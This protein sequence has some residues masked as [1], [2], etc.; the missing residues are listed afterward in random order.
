MRRHRARRGRLEGHRCVGCS[1]RLS[2]MQQ[3]AASIMMETVLGRSHSLCIWP[4]LPRFVLRS[5]PAA[6][7]FKGKS[8]A[9]GA[10]RLAMGRPRP[11]QAR[12]ACWSATRPCSPWQA[13]PPEAA[14]SSRF[15]STAPEGATAKGRIDPEGEIE[16]G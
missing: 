16:K 11:A 3:Q 1:W 13:P 14:C 10:R 2:D 15:F 5:E 9:I 7:R 8:Q 6:V 12:G 4:S